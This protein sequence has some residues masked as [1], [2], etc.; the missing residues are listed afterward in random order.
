MPSLLSYRFEQLIHQDSTV[1]DQQ[2]CRLLAVHLYVDELEK[3][4][5]FYA[6]LL[7]CSPLVEGTKSVSFLLADGISLVLNKVNPKESD[8]KKDTHIHSGQVELELETIELAGIRD[9]LAAAIN[10]GMN[11]LSFEKQHL[12]KIFSPNGLLLSF[13]QKIIE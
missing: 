11:W 6:N 2:R 7:S 1:Q 13:R 5:D 9:K 10:K 4:S 3:E 8:S 12:V